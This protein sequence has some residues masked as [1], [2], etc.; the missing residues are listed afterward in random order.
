MVIL[1]VGM[2][3]VI[4]LFYFTVVGVCCENVRGISGLLGNVKVSDR[5]D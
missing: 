2:F 1:I 4:C 5:V 3:Y